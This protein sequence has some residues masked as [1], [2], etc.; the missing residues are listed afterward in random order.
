MRTRYRKIFIQWKISSNIFSEIAD[1]VIEVKK[2]NRFATRSYL[3]KD[4][5]G[6]NSIFTKRHPFISNTSVFEIDNLQVV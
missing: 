2:G 6:E 5:L 1:R 4:R 3:F